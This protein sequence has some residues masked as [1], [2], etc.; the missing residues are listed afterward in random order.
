MSNIPNKPNQK[1]YKDLTP[2]DLVLIQKF[3]FIEEDFDAINLYGILSKIKEYLNNVIA[4]E[5]IVTENQESLYNS[6]NDLYD[7]VEYYFENLDVQDEINN[8]LDE[9][10]ENGTLE[11]IIAQYLTLNGLIIFN[12]LENMKNAEN[13]VEG[14]TIKTLGFYSKNDCGGN[15]YKVRKI[16][17][18][19]V[20]DNR[21]I[22]SLNNYNDLIAEIIFENNEVDIRKLGAKQ[23][24]DCSTIITK[25]LSLNKTVIIPKGLWLCNHFSMVNGGKIK[26]ENINYQ[27]IAN[28]SSLS[29]DISVLQCNENCDTFIDCSNCDHISLEICLSSCASKGQYLNAKNIREFIKLDHSC[30]S[31]FDIF[32]LCLN[33][34][35]LSIKNS[36]ENTFNRLY[37]R[38]ILNESVVDIKCESGQQGISQNVFN[39]VQSEGFGATILDF[40]EGL[41]Y[42][43][44]I[45]SILTELTP[46]EPFTRTDT[47]AAVQIPLIKIGDG[48]NNLIES[49]QI[50]NFSFKNAEIDNTIYEHSVF[51]IDSNNGSAF[52]LKVNDIIFD[53]GI[54]KPI[55][56]TKQVGEIAY[57]S[58]YLIIDNIT[59]PSAQP[60]R[61]YLENMNYYKIGNIFKRYSSSLASGNN[62]CSITEWY[63]PYD[64]SKTPMVS[65]ST[66]YNSFNNE[67]AVIKIATTSNKISAIK[68][69]PEETI[70]IYYKS[71]TVVNYEIKLLQRNNT[72]LDTITGTLDIASNFSVTDL[73]TSDKT[74]PL[75]ALI[76]F[77]SDGNTYIGD[78][79]K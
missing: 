14:S 43:N 4:N 1:P 79:T 12:T 63:K 29:N 11:E 72:V 67:N 73:Y 20:V 8:K 56:L 74:V 70:K 21:T 75:I 48:S 33:N 17:N 52:G 22:I 55:N 59:C 10:A 35:G 39:D 15:I 9:M 16:V 2:F 36:W 49:I 38:G 32:I 3:P 24:E 76:S 37:F 60:I 23:N 50:N 62:E 34:Y 31:Y 51:Y 5:Q 45:N 40:T 69:L 46:Y 30:F 54:T 27:V 7:Y 64:S 47:N 78:I 42:H 13:I 41:F 61:Q 18:T 58:S 66:N 44:K 25:L 53:T 65:D 71:D 57:L 26:G 77:S 6:F 19:D 68:I 28:D